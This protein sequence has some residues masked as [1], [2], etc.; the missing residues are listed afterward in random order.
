[1]ISTKLWASVY[2][3]LLSISYNI[4][5]LSL[6]QTSQSNCRQGQSKI[7]L[8]ELKNVS[9]KSLSL[10]SAESS[11]KRGRVSFWR[12]VLPAIAVVLVQRLLPGH[13]HPHQ[14]HEQEADEKTNSWKWEVLEWVQVSGECLGFLS[15]IWGVQT[16]Q[17]VTQIKLFVKWRYAEI[18]VSTFHPM[19][20]SDPWLLCIS[21]CWQ[22]L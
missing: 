5:K 14:G 18:S 2:F 10:V 22:Y 3:I 8:S 6:Y 20:E 11:H 12:I 4:Y 21:W 19:N 13:L 1:M 17:F 16:M 9:H 7:C 15:S